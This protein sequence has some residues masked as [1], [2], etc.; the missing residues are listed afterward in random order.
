LDNSTLAASFT[1]LDGH[2]GKAHSGANVW[3]FEGVNVIHRQ[4]SQNSK[5]LANKFERGIARH[6]V[7]A[8]ALFGIFHARQFSSPLKLLGSPS[9]YAIPFPLLTLAARGV[10]HQV[11]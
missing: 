4:Y 3:N 10:V 2:L 1:Q 5:Y 6:I 8:L 9:A 11:N 7:K